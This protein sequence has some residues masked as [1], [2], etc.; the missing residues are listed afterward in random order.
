MGSRQGRKS[1]AKRPGLS[2]LAA[3]PITIIIQKTETE[4]GGRS[5]GENGLAHRSREAL[6]PENAEIELL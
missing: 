2:G 1:A 4:E 5:G 3:E 6:P